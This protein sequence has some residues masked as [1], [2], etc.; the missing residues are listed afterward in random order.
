MGESRSGQG[1][2]ITEN[3]VPGMPGTET[4]EAPPPEE[5]IEHLEALPR[6]VGWM[7]LISGLLSEFGMIGMPPF[8][9]FGVLILWPRMGRPVVGLLGRRAPRALRFGVR[10]VKRFAVDLD[11]RYP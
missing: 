7:L 9:V 11:T 4:T 2:S 10:L 6:D 5:V 3:D 1:L 8:W